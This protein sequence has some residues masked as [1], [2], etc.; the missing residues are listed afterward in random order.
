MKAK[1]PKSRKKPSPTPARPK[2]NTASKPKTRKPIAKSK[3]KSALDHVKRKSSTRRLNR[4][5]ADRNTA[6]DSLKKTQIK[7]EKLFSAQRDGILI[8]DAKSKR[9]TDANESACKL[10]GYT[11]EELLQLTISE[12]SAKPQKFILEF[13]MN[14]ESK[15]YPLLYFKT[16]SG[17]KIPIEITTGMFQIKNKSFVFG[18]FRDITQQIKNQETIKRKSMQLEKSN[19]ALK[20]FVSIASH[21][22][23]APLRKIIS[24]SSRIEIEKENM[25]PESLEY[26]ERMQQTA[27]RMQKLLDDLLLYSRLSAQTYPFQKINLKTILT[28]VLEDLGLLQNHFPENIKIGSLPKVEANSTQIRQLFQNLISNA[29][30]FQKKD[31]PLRIEIN[32]R[33]IDR[34]LLEIIIRDHGIGFDETHLDRIFRPFERLHGINE[35][36]G[37]GMGLAICKNIV[38]SHGGTITAESQPDHGARFIF[39][40]QKTAPCKS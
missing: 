1:T 13:I 3:P 29:I 39:T 31:V 23:Q 15:T 9:I 12:L 17:S 27:F 26:L 20:N 34:E 25:R 4:F 21:D 5:I 33:L 37:T 35:Y 30:K 6:L 36:E 28:D 16:K 8:S 11:R 2:T 18:I 40:L 19:Q 10:F 38:E 14:C 32:G 7:Y 24:F 22:L